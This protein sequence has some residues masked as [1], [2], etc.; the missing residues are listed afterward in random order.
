MATDKDVKDVVLGAGAVATVITSLEFYKKSVQR[1]ARAATVKEVEAAYTA[2]VAR[3]DELIAKF[4]GQREL[5]L[6]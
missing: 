6:A 3:L 2:E 1:A 5:R 4:H